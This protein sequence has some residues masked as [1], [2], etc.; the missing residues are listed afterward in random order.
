MFSNVPWD[1]PLRTRRIDDKNQPISDE[2]YRR[3]EWYDITS[4]TDPG[5]VR[6]LV[7]LPWRRHPVALPDPPAPGEG[8]AS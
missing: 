8:S 3:Y 5:D 4:I 2:E 6:R 1:S 7:R